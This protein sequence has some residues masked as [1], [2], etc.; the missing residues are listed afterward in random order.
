VSVPD[1]FSYLFRNLVEKTNFNFSNLANTK[2]FLSCP[3]D[4]VML[5]QVDSHAISSKYI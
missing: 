2:V 1:E 5:R 3:K 4:D